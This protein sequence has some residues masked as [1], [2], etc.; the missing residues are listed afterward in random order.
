MSEGQFTEELIAG[1]HK[2]THDKEQVSLANSSYSYCKD[3]GH[4]QKQLWRNKSILTGFWCLEQCVVHT[5]CS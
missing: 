5:G 1:K 3:N 4:R 2:N